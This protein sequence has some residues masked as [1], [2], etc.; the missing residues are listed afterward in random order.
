MQEKRRIVRASHRSKDLCLM[1]YDRAETEIEIEGKCS[2]SPVI[3]DDLNRRKSRII[4]DG[5]W[6][7]I[8]MRIVA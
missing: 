6:S 3:V 5:I 7:V 2:L 8:L 4:A 1:S